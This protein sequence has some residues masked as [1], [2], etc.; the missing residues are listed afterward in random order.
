MTWGGSWG[1]P[2][3]DTVEF[4]DRDDDGNLLPIPPGQLDASATATAR[5]WKVLEG[6]QT[7][8]D[9]MSVFGLLFQDVEGVIGQLSTQIYRETAEG[10]QLD[11]I[12]ALV[13]RARGGQTDDADYRRAILAEA[14]SLIASGT[15]ED[16]IDLADGLAPE[17]L[18]AI[19]DETYP[20]ALVMTIPDL[21]IADWYLILEIGADV[22]PM[23]VGAWLAT[24]STTTSAGWGWDPQPDVAGAFGWDPQPAGV[25]STW[26][27]AQ[28]LG[29]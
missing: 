11:K 9:M 28:R 12:G 20:A 4:G 3:G 15:P 24:Y 2:W 17:G 1:Q 14:L 23:G 22:P 26:S 13:G 18:T 21:P 27:W 8:R 5:L 19:Y 6:A 16:I 10:V 7:W 29:T 25:L